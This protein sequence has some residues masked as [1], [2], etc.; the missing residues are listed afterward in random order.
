MDSFT[1]FLDAIPEKG[2]IVVEYYWQPRSLESHAKKGKKA[3]GTKTSMVYFRPMRASDRCWCGSG[4]AFSRCHRRKDD[5]TFV[6]LDPGSKTYSPVV[7]LERTFSVPTAPHLQQ[8]LESDGTLLPVEGTESLTEWCVPIEP[9]IVNDTGQL[10]LGTVGLSRERVHLG[11]NSEKRF[12]HLTERF[13]ELL[14]ASAEEE[15]TI[16][17]A[18]LQATPKVRLTRKRRTGRS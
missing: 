17:A 18:P 4:R 11:T 13:Q 10:V 1:S 8:I 6:T 3:S 7:L 12:A 14:G 2:V 9:E 16:R 15:A 5:W